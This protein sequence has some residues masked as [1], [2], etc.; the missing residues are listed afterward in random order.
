MP[1]EA[2]SIGN[3]AF[4]SSN[5][6]NVINPEGINSIGNSAFSSASS[7]VSVTIPETVVHIG[8]SAF[9]WCYKLEHVYCRAKTPPAIVN[10]YWGWQAFD[11]NK[12]GRKIYVPS[13]SVDV[14]RT[15]DGWKDYAA[16]IV[17]YDF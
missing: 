8:S 13:E 4:S 11:S 1:A 9:R 3:S 17:G 7:I 12:A 15:A 6:I 14:F 2:K 5:L 16:D 10:T